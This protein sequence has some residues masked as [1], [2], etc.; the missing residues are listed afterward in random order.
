MI[1]SRSST[2]SSSADARNRALAAAF[3]LL[4]AALPA[5]A[6]AHRQDRL[7]LAVPYPIE[8]APSFPA[9]LFHWIDSLAG[10][11]PG[12]TVPAHRAEYL[13]LFGRLTGEDAT[14]L[15]AFVAARA[16]HA[17]REAANAQRGGVPPRTSAMLGV[18]CGSTTVDAAL[19][20]LEPELTRDAWDGLAKALAH[21]SPR[22]E[23]VWNDG[24]V[25]RAFLESARRDPGRQQL[26]ALLAKIVR[27]FGVD[28]LAIPPPRLAL[29]PVPHGFGTHAEAIGGVLFLEICSG[30]TL[31]DEASVIVHE[32]SHFLWNLVP[33]ERQRR[34]AAFAAGLDANG[35][36][37]FRLFGE[38]IPTAL[39]QGVADRL[40]RPSSWSL[41]GPWYHTQEI[42]ACAKRIFAAVS[43]AL[44]AGLTLDEELVRRA[45]Q[46]AD[47][48]R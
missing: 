33:T 44:D 12:K 25:P 9:G 21:F 46:A 19:A 13:R 47:G 3:A 42:D 18:F 20:R 27:F 41:D 22:Y 37:T 48:P 38:A 30:D 2:T 45:I 43:D 16:E 5:A 29:V 39:G 26:A 1:P 7:L 15:E 4:T 36:R 8:A 32:N 31:A 17:Q 34:L 28:P 23:V 24:A 14:H 35:A 40:F 6:A 10:T 11:T